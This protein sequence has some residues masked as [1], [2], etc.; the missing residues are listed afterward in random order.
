MDFANIFNK[1]KTDI[2]PEHSKH[3]I[4]IKFENKKISSMRPIYDFLH[5]ELIVLKEYIDEI[6]VKG[7]IVS[8]KSLIKVP[9]LFFFK[10]KQR[11]ML[12]C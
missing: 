1:T 2:L 3:D 9:V 5:T 10:K 12:L 7:F 11:L 6:L 8:F 4:A